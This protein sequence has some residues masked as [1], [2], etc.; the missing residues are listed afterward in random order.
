MRPSFRR[1][2]GQL[3]LLLQLEEFA[4]LRL[5][6]E[7]HQRLLP[8]CMR[9]SVSARRAR[10]PSTPPFLAAA[11]NLPAGILDPCFTPNCLCK[12]PGCFIAPLIQFF[13]AILI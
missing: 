2:L 8:T 10:L 4:F 9:S 6:L 11:R 1:S 12:A 3:A 7:G 13:L 5:R